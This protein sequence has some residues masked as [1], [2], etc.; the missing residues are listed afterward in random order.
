MEVNFSFPLQELEYFLLIL[1]R[2]TGF[3]TAAPFFGQNNTPH[4]FKISF[5]LFISFLLYEVI[6]PHVYVEYTTLFGYTI[7]ILKEAVTG[8]L[9]GLMANWAMQ[10]AV[11]AGQVVDTNIGFSMAQQMDPAT[12]MNITVSGSIYQYA[13]MLIFIV[14]GMYRWLLQALTE[15]YQLI[16]V[17]AAS[18]NMD[19]MYN[20]LVG[21]MADY[22]MI[23][24]RIGLPVFCVILLLNG[25]LGVMAKVAP[26][27]TMFAVGIQI[28]ALV[29]LVI[30]FVTMR[31]LPKAADMVFTEM[32]IAVV[33]AIE[34]LGGSL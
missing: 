22:I 13:F 11:F 33:S 8:M 16:P 17:G 23:G 24:F 10:I 32:R 27:M 34:G 5:S 21:F 9:I 28:K 14:T 2:V 7:F 19:R 25:L 12:Q 18:L 31:M 15:S 26:Q 29:G 1:V 20:G 6:T 4:Q 3:V 30:L